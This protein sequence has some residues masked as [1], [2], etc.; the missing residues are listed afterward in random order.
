MSAPL[1]EQVL[2]E[3]STWF[4]EYRSGP[5]SAHAQEQ[6]MAWLRR[7]P[8]HI[9]AYL[10][11]SRAYVDLPAASEVPRGEVERLLAKFEVRESDKVVA[12]EE[13]TPRHVSVP[14]PSPRGGALRSRLTLA[15]SLL[16]VIGGA[17]SGYLWTQRGLYVTGRGESRTVTLE[18]ASRIELNA[19]SRLRVRY[20]KSERDVD[21]LEG[22]AFF[23]VAKDKQRPFVVRAG[24]AR[25]RAVGTEFDVYRHGSE[26]TVTVL[27]GTVAVLPDVTSPL[28]S[29]LAMPDLLVTAGEQAIVTPQGNQKAHT[30]NVSAATAWTRGQLEF[31]ETP[32]S[33]VADQFN[34]S[35]TRVLVLDSQ[36]LND[37]RISGVYSSVDPTSLILFLKSQ[38]DL[39]VT[40]SGNQIE[41]QARG[42]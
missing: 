4:I 7:S 14:A 32:L 40:E 10:D 1:N 29:R 34:R 38:P 13:R 33:E 41:V 25:V 24:D 37:I 19:Y 17:I 22:Q 28:P 6:F 3:A 11:V 20:S 31:D 12:L 2:M 36:A 27:E 15:A 30:A 16:L 35:S 39:L 9:R 18:D 23:Q 5:L 8:E 42:H 21:L 26:T